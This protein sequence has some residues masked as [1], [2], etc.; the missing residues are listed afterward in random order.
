[1]SAADDFLRDAGVV[2]APNVQQSAAQQFLQD[3]QTPPSGPRRPLKPPQELSL[4][5]R[6][7][8]Q[9][10]A[11]LVNN[12]AMTA[13]RGTVM[14]GA[15]P[16]VGTAQ[17]A[18]N[19]LPDSTGIPQAVNQSVS[20]KDAQY[21]AERKGQGMA[22]VDP[23]RIAGNFISPV[24][25]AMALRAV[26]AVTAGA[27]AVQGAVT[28]FVGGASAPVDVGTSGKYWAPKAV[29]TTI[30]T[31]AGGV[32]APVTGWIGDKAIPM[33][34]SV[35]AKFKGGMDPAAAAAQTDSILSSA[36]SESGQ[37]IENIPPAQLDAVRQQVSDALSKGKK[38][39]AA[40]A[41]RLADFQ[42]EGIPATQA[43][44]TRDP[45]QFADEQTMKAISRPLSQT[46]EL[47][48]KKVTQGIGQYSANAE[49]APVASADLASA[50]RSYDATK[51][52]GVSQAYAG[53]RAS[54]MGADEIPMQ[55]LAQDVTG[56]VDTLPENVKKALPLGAFDKYGIFSGKQRKALTY[57]DAENLLQTLNASKNNDPATIRAIG[58]L[59]GFVKDAISQGG[60]NGPY[61]AARQLAAQRFS[62]QEAI[63][64]LGAAT[65]GEAGDN[66]VQKYV[67]N[68]QTQDVQKLAAL[69]RENA[70]DAFDQ[71][72]QQIGAHLARKAFGEN[73]AAD[74]AV[75]QESYNKALRTLGTGKLEAFFEPQEV[76]QLQR[77]GR[78]SAYQQSNPAAAAS[79]FSNTAGAIANLL[80]KMPEGVP[81]AG[82]S[83][84]WMGKK[85]GGYA[86]MNPQVPITGNMSDAQLLMLSNL[87][88]GGSGAAGLGLAG[89][90][91]Q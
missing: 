69:L 27:R 59:N 46:M 77:L 83:I 13:V 80:R 61:A 47:G 8:A 55:G 28:G 9:V 49:E 29:Q 42:A 85:L 91:G 18:A 16:V 82:P 3:A 5:D 64:A 32:L 10:P 66:F 30:A 2:T 71:T 86:A 73:V 36:L 81:V 78:I 19:L 23:A 70:P 68:G 25:L 54:A 22:G 89:A 34:N 26:P 58:K 87:L 39:D 67:I 4:M 62:Q 57:D 37:K 88:R 74:K 20:D 6:L 50:L 38:L 90:I 7:L 56:F 44:I 65:S 11:G 60:D 76:D 48:N 12:R 17:A 51:E 72:R 35:I 41:L 33:V 75:A 40:A 1:M 21:Q 79:N 15:D 53:A 31:A 43:A 24:N 84:Q 63:P 45:M 14:G 52:S